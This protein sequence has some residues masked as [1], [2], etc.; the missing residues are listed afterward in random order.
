MK[1]Q[2][3]DACWLGDD[4]WFHRGTIRIVN[5]RIA[6]LESA[7][8]ADAPCGDEIVVPGLI[9]A[10]VHLREPGQAYKEGIANGTAAALKGGVATVLDM[11]NNRPP[12]ATRE[13]FEQKRALFARKSR[14]NYGLFWQAADGGES[15]PETAA[16]AKIYMAQSSSLP[17]IGDADAL[18]RIFRAQDLVVVHAEDER[19]FFHNVEKSFPQCGKNVHHLR[20]PRAAVLAAL[21]SLEIALRKTPAKARPR[22]VVAHCGTVEE[23]AW[24]RKMK[25]AG[26]DVW[27]ETCPHY[28]L[29]TEEDYLRRGAALQVNPPLRSEEDRA[30][31][32]EAVKNGG[33]DFVSTDHAP[34]A[35][36]EKAGKNPPSGIAAIEWLGPILLTLA[37]R[38]EISWKRYLELSGRNAARCYGIEGRGGIRAGAWADLAFVALGRAAKGAREKV[39]TRAKF[40]PYA[41]F[42]FAARVRAMR[43][44]GQTAWS[45][46]RAR[47][48]VRGKEVFA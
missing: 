39:A 38:G 47:P 8:A 42:D 3:D 35:S 26:Y 41:E 19:R 34:H 13:L 9:D 18:A 16:G 7:F 6:K 45:D 11:P 2:I 31:I 24:V 48:G 30:A 21:A 36:A 25:R 10:H 12:I 22:L 5:G 1:F 14:V 23:L 32:F 43:I 29:L 20:R 44:N 28:F 40:R 15:A 46:G 33:I 37:K 4:G 17:A 27:A